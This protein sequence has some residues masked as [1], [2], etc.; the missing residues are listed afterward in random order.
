MNEL[1]LILIA[2]VIIVAVAWGAKYVIENFFPP[3][4]HMPALLIVGLILLIALL[5]TVARY[6]GLPSLR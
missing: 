4:L 6:T 5:L 1:I 2:L 3:A